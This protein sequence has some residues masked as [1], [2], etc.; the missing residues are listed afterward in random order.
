M[1]V[2]RGSA[3]TLAELRR[4]A[5]MRN[6]SGDAGGVTAAVVSLRVPQATANGALPA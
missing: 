2:G 6:A 3:G 4:A 5:A 1:L